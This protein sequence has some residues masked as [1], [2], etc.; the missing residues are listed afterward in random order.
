MSGSSQQLHP[1]AAGQHEDRGLWLGGLGWKVPSALGWLL[2]SP[3][4]CRGGGVHHALP[5][6]VGSPVSEGVSVLVCLGGWR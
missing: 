5:G 1:A 3:M 6:M 2:S 4:P